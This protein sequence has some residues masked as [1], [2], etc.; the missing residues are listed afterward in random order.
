MKLLLQKVFPTSEIQRPTGLT[1][2]YVGLLWMPGSS[3]SPLMWWRLLPCLTLEVR[4]CKICTEAC[5]ILRVSDLWV[6]CPSGLEETQTAASV[7]PWSTGIWFD[8]KINL[9]VLSVGSPKLCFSGNTTCYNEIQRGKKY[10]QSD[11]QTGC[12]EVTVIS[13]SQQLQG[14]CAVMIV[15][16]TKVYCVIHE[17]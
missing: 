16:L 5:L 8:C 11:A 2:V 7:G 3:Q 15:F 13:R 17:V 1:P 14:H 10:K 12:E 9:C 6:S 4:V